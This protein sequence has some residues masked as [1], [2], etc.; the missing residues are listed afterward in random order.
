MCL[1]E[2]ELKTSGWT[3]ETKETFAPFSVSAQQTLPVDFLVRL[4]T[5]NH[6]YGTRKTK[7]L[8]HNAK[9]NRM[10][11]YLEHMTEEEKSSCKKEHLEHDELVGYMFKR[12]EISD[13]E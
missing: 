8:D 1:A 5:G 6:L 11:C 3:E 4:N 2:Q 12:D 10:H 7:E 13:D 9:W